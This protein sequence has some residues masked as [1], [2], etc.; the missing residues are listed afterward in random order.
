MNNYLNFTLI[1]VNEYSKLIELEDQVSNQKVSGAFFEVLH[2]CN[3]LYNQITSSFD[4]N[5]GSSLPAPILN[6]DFL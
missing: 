5:F 2:M 3:G 6:Y 4:L 1:C